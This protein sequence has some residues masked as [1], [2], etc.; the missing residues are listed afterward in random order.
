MTQETHAQS[1]KPLLRPKEAAVFLG[2]SIKT[3]G[4]MAVKRIAYNDRTLRYRQEDLVEAKERRA[5]LMVLHPERYLGQ[6]K[7]APEYPCLGE[8][9]AQRS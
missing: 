7:P 6:V 3:L 8:Q 1:L 4:R 5:F 9:H 2:V